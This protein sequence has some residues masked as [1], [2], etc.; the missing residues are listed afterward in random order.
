MQ[1]KQYSKYETKQGHI[2]IYTGLADGTGRE[3]LRFISFRFVVTTNWDFDR[4]IVGALLI[5]REIMDLF[6]VVVRPF[7]RLSSI[8]IVAS[9]FISVRVL[10]LRIGS[11]NDVMKSVRSSCVSRF[12]FNNSLYKF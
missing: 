11:S 12:P 1:T 5:L 9:R 8:A 10:L 2:G 3:E 7:G 4:R 6:V